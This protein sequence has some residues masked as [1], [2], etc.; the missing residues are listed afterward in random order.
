MSANT[1]ASA[2]GLAYLGGFMANKG[3]FNGRTIMSGSAWDKVHANPTLEPDFGSG[4]VTRFT[5]GGLDD[6]TKPN[7]SDKVTWTPG[8]NE[9]QDMGRGFYGWFGLGGS[10]F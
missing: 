3:T 9:Q 5:D 6:L 8:W 4:M 7:V 1:K 2:R 10:S